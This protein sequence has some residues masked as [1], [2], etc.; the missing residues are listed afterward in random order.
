[1]PTKYP[2]IKAVLKARLLGGRYREGHPM[3]SEAQVALEFGVSRM[4]ARRAMDELEREGL[5]SRVQG[6]GSFPT[7]R[8]FSQGAFR[9]RPLEEIAGSRQAFTRVLEAGL[10]RSTPDVAD[11]LGLARGSAVLNVVR[12]RGVDSEPLLLERR[13]LRV[14]HAESLLRHNLAVESIHDLL[15]SRLGLDLARV[16]QTL[17]AICLGPDEARHLALP[18]GR[19]AFLLTRT[20]WGADGPLG[21]AR[22]WVRGDRD[23][24][25]GDFEP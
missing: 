20:T 15:V 17:E 8:R 25:L 2:A 19:A 12:L 10:V 7:G 3:P 14:D 24:F 11:A 18:V 6:S 16:E 13:A 9:I 22:Y 5:I 1:M 21:L 4:T 23:T